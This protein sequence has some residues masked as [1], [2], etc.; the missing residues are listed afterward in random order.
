MIP[1]QADDT[2]PGQFEGI[3]TGIRQL[4]RTRPPETEL[5]NGVR[6]PTLAEMA[7]INAWH[8]ATR[9]TVGDYLDTVVLL[10]RLGTEAA[11]QAFGE[12]DEIY[13][14]EST[15]PL[16]EVVERLAAASL[17]NRAEVKLRDFNDLGAS[18]NNWG[19]LSGRGRCWAAVLAAQLLSGGAPATM[20]MERLVTSW[21][22]SR[23]DLDSDEVLA[24]ILDRGDLEAWR[25]LYRIAAADPLLRTR[26]RG[27]VR[28]VP[29]PFPSFWL[30]A[31]ASL[32]ERIDWQMSLPQDCGV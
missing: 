17:S 16:A 7:R 26:I 3:V 5:V 23:L 27:V 31:L 4:C 32:G 24:Q 18:W 14:Q 12:F 29:L 10:E 25:E 11:L 9:H 2:N 15:S 8:L 6:V 13:A 19:H 30:A 22:R 1:V 20:S 21:N 28:R